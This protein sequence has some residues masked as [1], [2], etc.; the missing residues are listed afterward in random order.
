MTKSAE[1]L[2]TRCEWCEARPNPEGP[3]RF[4]TP[5]GPIGPD[6]E[7]VELCLSAQFDGGKTTIELEDVRDLDGKPRSFDAR[8]TER[9]NEV[10]RTLQEKA[11]CGTL[12]QCPL[13]VTRRAREARIPAARM[14]QVVT[15]TAF[16]K[17]LSSQD[18]SL[19][20]ETSRVRHLSPKESLVHDGESCRGFF[21]VLKGL[22]KVCRTNYDGRPFNLL[23][24]EPG[25]VFA[26]EAV[27]LEQPHTGNAESITEATVLIVKPSTFR[28]L[29]EKDSGFCKRVLRVL[30]LRNEKLLRMSAHLATGQSMSKIARYLLEQFR[31]GPNPIRLRLPK[32]EI[33][34]LVGVAPETL[35]RGL[36]SM[37]ESRIIEVEG[38]TVWIEDPESLDELALAC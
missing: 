28:T 2:G 14:I 15:D 35:S 16:F 36:R 13:V 31:R 37:Q 29:V 3:V 1:A 34:S 30:A 9:I 32:F 25:D 11:N 24:L 17:G 7:D 38:R 6:S 18:L 33:A 21:V 27:L 5:A 12:P 4:R 19:I 20:A 26:E 8:T 23:A 22:L 10:V